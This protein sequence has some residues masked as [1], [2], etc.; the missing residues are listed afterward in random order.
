[1]AEQTSSGSG[2]SSGLAPNVA[3]LLSYLCV[4]LTGIIFLLIEKNNQDVRFHAAQGIVLGI[5]GVVLRIIIFIL[6]MIIPFFGFLSWIIW[7]GFLAITIVAM[8]KGYQMERWKIPVLG[9]FAEKLIK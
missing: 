6:T 3:A 1:M 4:P 8:V 9:D 2:G 7:L 5:A